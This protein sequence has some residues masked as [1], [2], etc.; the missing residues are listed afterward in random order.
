MLRE[1]EPDRRLTLNLHQA[2]NLVA[3]VCPSHGRSRFAPLECFALDSGQL[4]MFCGGM[5]RHTPESVLIR[6]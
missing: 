2:C 3:V 5:K 6:I 4:S 1:V